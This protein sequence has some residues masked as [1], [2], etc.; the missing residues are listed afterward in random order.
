MTADHD[1]IHGVEALQDLLNNHPNSSKRKESF[2][3]YQNS[4]LTLY[5]DTLTYA[6]IAKM[7]D[8]ELTAYVKIVQHDTRH[9]N[10]SV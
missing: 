1:L 7:S 5:T 9:M 10:A 3:T 6:N 2:E 4:L 8:D